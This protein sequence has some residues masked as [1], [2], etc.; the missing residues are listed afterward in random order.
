MPRLIWVFAGHTAHFVSFVTL[1]LNYEIRWYSGKDSS[2]KVT[3]KYLCLRAIH[4]AMVANDWCIYIKFNF[5]FYLQRVI[6]LFITSYI[7]IRFICISWQR[8]IYFFSEVIDFSSKT[9]K[10]WSI[11]N[12]YQHYDIPFFLA[13]EHLTHISLASQFLGIGKQCRPRSELGDWSGSS[14]FANRNIQN[15][16]KMKKYT[17]HP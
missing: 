7:V 15:R 14:L 3:V 9:C 8:Y 12:L 17:K 1:R 13:L 5:N 6:P 16:I 2:R 11:S 10:L 4:K